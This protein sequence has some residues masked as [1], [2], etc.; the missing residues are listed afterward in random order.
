MSSGFKNI[1]KVDSKEDSKYVQ[2]FVNI[3]VKSF[4]AY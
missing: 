1:L 2:T 4:M 3:G